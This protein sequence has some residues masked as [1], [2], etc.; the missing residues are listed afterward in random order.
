MN[1]ISYMNNAFHSI[2]GTHQ[3]ITTQSLPGIYM[4]GALISYLGATGSALLYF[5]DQF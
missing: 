2:L 5:I 4:S 1:L 3:E